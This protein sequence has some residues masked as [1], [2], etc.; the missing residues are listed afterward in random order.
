[1][2]NQAKHPARGDDAAMIKLI[3]RCVGLGDLIAAL[4]LHNGWFGQTQNTTEAIWYLALAIFMM[5][6]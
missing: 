6:A 5:M 4:A 2:E 3:F 1:M